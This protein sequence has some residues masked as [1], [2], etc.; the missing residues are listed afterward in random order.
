MTEAFEY[1]AE[2]QLTDGSLVQLD[3][4]ERGWAEPDRLSQTRV[5]TLVPKNP[6]AGMPFVRVHIP[7]DAK[8]I[9]KSRMVN[10]LLGPAANYMGEPVFRLYAA[11][12]FKDGESYWTWVMP[13]G[14]VEQNTDEPTIADILL[15]AA[16]QS[17][18]IEKQNAIGSG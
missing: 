18:A 14:S 9:F 16:N 6:A 8:P 1:W 12:Y 13:N 17:S 2:L 5:F 11:G 10:R 4:E 3:L 7:E 15:Q